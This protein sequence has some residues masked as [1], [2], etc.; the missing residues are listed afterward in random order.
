MVGRGGGGLSSR[1]RRRFSKELSVGSQRVD[2]GR[3]YHGLD[4]HENYF[5]LCLLSYRDPY[6]NVQTMAGQRPYGPAVETRPGQLSHYP[7]APARITSNKAILNEA[8]S[9]KQSY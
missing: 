2:G 4:Q 5:R 7:Q 9:G 8:V 3:P 1:S 6:R